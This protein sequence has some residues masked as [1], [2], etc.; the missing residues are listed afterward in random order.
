MAEFLTGLCCHTA[1]YFLLSHRCFSF[2]LIPVR[3]PH[4]DR[5]VCMCMFSAA[6]EVCVATDSVFS[7]TDKLP[8]LHYS[9]A[10]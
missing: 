8:L 2:Y 10:L 3:F 5:T 1:L 7:R 9:T 6:R 4:I